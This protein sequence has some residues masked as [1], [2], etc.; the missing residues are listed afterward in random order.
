MHDIEISLSFCSG[1]C[2]AVTGKLFFLYYDG[3]MH[4]LAGGGWLA[5]C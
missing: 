4:K 2:L 3:W 5:G 1:C